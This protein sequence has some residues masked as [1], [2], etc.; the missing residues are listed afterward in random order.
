MR[1]LSLSTTTTF[2]GCFFMPQNVSKTP[3]GAGNRNESTNLTSNCNLTI[4]DITESDNP[5]N[6]YLITKTP[7]VTG[8]SAPGVGNIFNVTNN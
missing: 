3:R 4:V 2:T 5:S 6:A 1:K 8:T 7:L